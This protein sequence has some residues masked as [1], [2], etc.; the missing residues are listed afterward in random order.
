MTHTKLAIIFLST[1]IC[2]NQ[3]QKCHVTLTV[4]ETLLNPGTGTLFSRHSGN[5][6]LKTGSLCS[7]RVGVKRNRTPRK[8]GREQFG[9]R[10]KWGKSKAVRKKL[11]RAARFRSA[12]K[13]TLAMQ[14]R[15]L[16]INQSRKQT[17]RSQFT[18]SFTVNAETEMPIDHL[19]R[20][21][22]IVFFFSE[23][24]LPS[25]PNNTE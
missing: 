21:R 22:P 17:D 10:E 12:R 1:S 19:L 15:K 14:A 18:V 25:F 4:N 24:D 20:S 23:Q 6:S 13:G 5:A 9:P 16:A 3:T 11:F 7:K 2:I 8:M